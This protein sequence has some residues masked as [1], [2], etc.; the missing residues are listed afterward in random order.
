MWPF[1]K[2]TTRRRA[3]EEIKAETREFEE[4][5][6][7][8]KLE[9]MQ[10]SMDLNKIYEKKSIILSKTIDGIVDL[11]ENLEQRGLP[12]A[13]PIKQGVVG[14]QLSDLLLG[15]INDMDFGTKGNSFK[16]AAAS[17]IE[18]KKPQLNAYLEE[19]GMP[20]IENIIAQ[21]SKKQVATK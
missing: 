21:A 15:A 1:T 13:M 12:E 20:I 7:D 16:K 9:V 3:I 8:I 5:R 14:N 11:K 10:A 2:K 4:L 17:V 18:S 6:D 19:K